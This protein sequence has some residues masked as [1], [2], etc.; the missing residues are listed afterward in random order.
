MS[1]RSRLFLQYS[2]NIR[3]RFVNFSSAQGKASFLDI[4]SGKDFIYLSLALDKCSNKAIAEKLHISEKSV[5][6]KYREIYDKLGIKNRQELMDM[7]GFSQKT[8]Q[9]ES[10]INDS[11]NR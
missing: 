4:L 5:S 10:T 11:D 1:W 9:A 3:K 2:H 7:I 8:E 6:R